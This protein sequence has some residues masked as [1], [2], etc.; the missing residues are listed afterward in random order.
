MKK[1][2]N[3]LTN[4][5]IC[6][7]FV[8]LGALTVSAEITQKDLMHNGEKVGYQVFGLGEAGNEIAVVFTKTDV[9]IPW[10]VPYDLKNVEFLV[11][12]GGGGGGASAHYGSSSPTLA[13]AGGGG[14]GVITGY[15]NFDENTT[16]LINVGQGGEGGK[17][18]AY[19]KGTNDENT[20][21]SGASLP[22]NPSVVKVGEAEYVKAMGGGNCKGLLNH[23]GE[24]ASNGGCRKCDGDG[25]CSCLNTVEKTEEE[26]EAKKD[27]YFYYDERY[28]FN[29]NRFG[30][31]GGCTYK[32]EKPAA[33]GGGGGAAGVGGRAKQVSNTKTGYTDG[34]A[35]GP[36]LESM[37]TG[38]RL[39]F[40]SGGGGGTSRKVG[41]TNQPNG[42]EGGKGGEG[43]GDG[44]KR[45]SDDNVKH[46]GDAIA[47]QGGGGG[48]AAYKGNG[49]NG[50]SGIVV[51]RYAL[52]DG[53]ALIP[54]IKSK[55]YNG[56][57]QKADV[58]ES[59][60]YTVAQSGGTDVGSYDVVL[61]L[62]EGYKWS[63][64]STAPITFEFNITPAVNKW[65]SEPSITKGS[66]TVGE[67][68]GELY[69]GKT[70]FGEIIARISKGGVDCGDF[71]GVIPTDP[72]EYEITYSVAES[73]NYTNVDSKTVAFTI[74]AADGIPPYT[75]SVGEPSVNDN[76]ELSISGSLSCEATTSK[77]A[78]IIAVYTIED[79]GVTNELSFATEI[80]LNGGAF[81]GMIRD[82]MPGATY[83]V[84]V[85]SKVGEEA[86]ALTEFKTV[87]VPGVAKNLTAEAT[88]TTTP[89][90]KF[91]ITGSV[92][93]GIGE[94][95]VTLYYSLNST[96]C[97]STME[98]VV[99]D[100]GTFA[101]E[102]SYEK[103]TDN[104]S[105][106]VTVVNT[107]DTGT[108][109]GVLN[110]GETTKVTTERKEAAHS[111]YVWTGNGEDNL[112]TNPLN[113]E[114]SNN[115]CYG[116]PGVKGINYYLSW[117]E[118]VS[119]PSSPIDLSGGVYNF[120]DNGAFVV[121]DG[122]AVEFYNGT[123]RVHGSKPMNNGDDYKIGRSNSTMT[124]N[125]VN[126]DNLN[127]LQPI[128]GSTIEFKGT[129]TQ[130][131]KYKPYTGS[132][133]TKFV[134]RDGVLTTGY[135]VAQPGSGSEVLIS[136][137]VWVVTNAIYEKD[138]ERGLAKV[139]KFRDG[140]DNQAR[141]LLCK[142]LTDATDYTLELY[143]TY[144][145]KIPSDGVTDAYVVADYVS[146]VDNFDKF[147]IDVTDYA[148]GDLIPLIYQSGAG[149]GTNT[150]MKDFIAERT[151]ALQLIANGEDV[152]SKRNGRL[153]WDYD[154][155]TLYFQQDIQAVAQIGDA[156][157]TSLAEAIEAA[158]AGD[159][160]TLVKDIELTSYLEITKSITLDFNEKSIS[161]AD[162]TGIYVNDTNAE[163]VLTN[164]TIEASNIPV[165]VN[166]AKTVDIYDCVVR[167]TDSNEAVYVQNS[168]H[169]R[170][171]SGTFSTDNQYDGKYWVLNINDNYRDTAKI[172]VYGGTFVNFNPQNCDTEVEGYNNFCADGYKAAAGD[173]AGT[174]VVR[175]AMS[176]LKPG[177]PV[178]NISA[179]SEEDAIRKVVL[180][181]EVPAGANITKDDY[182]KYFKLVATETSEGSGIWEVAAVLDD[183]K[184]T[185]VIAATTDE[186][187]VVTP[188]IT[189]EDG[190]VTVNIENELPGLNYGVRY[191]TTVEA[192]DAAEI[193]PGFTVTPAEGDTAGFFK[194]VVDFK[195]IK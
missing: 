142:A 76:R 136:N 32:A 159:T 152:T 46:G 88:F 121:G 13:G 167:N 192:V 3:Y 17:Y 66:W 59:E 106:Y 118:F 37:I 7:A 148:K 122:V 130:G 94:T 180:T 64:N 90:K 65:V 51:L 107:F 141:L 115:S 87:T 91:V 21:G 9:D 58:P 187:G 83:S 33:A 22:G 5:A 161:R 120:I 177:V 182:A 173:V 92:T 67:V 110:G 146:S 97:A 119:S 124:F 23:G 132:T 193:V 144:D 41:T 123:L 10:T 150:R 25:I 53:V 15:V 89:D 78:E 131:W 149:T 96:E 20:S 156:K 158:S 71:D 151:D 11:V 63:D 24:G 61:T 140:A 14:G 194:V 185:P 50:G 69:C 155:K 127:I 164:G 134:V 171:Y 170:I 186:N 56:E 188:A 95:K 108:W 12:G 172:E 40:G 19:K 26:K 147:V 1:I 153:V 160:I 84:A 179:T 39:V 70:T 34:G 74:V 129:T 181:V 101:F 112:W 126:I 98:Q 105:W 62:N 116:Y 72:G 111:K 174:W 166:H 176:E 165:Y 143:G 175:K 125:E 18:S 45:G 169:V 137:A 44:A 133:S 86:S 178:T 100:D 183:T 99:N 157:F 190:N 30:N 117:V 4:K 42:G 8:V 138:E 85:Y 47:N 145:I 162:G 73:I 168:G 38:V 52:P 77:M 68:S 82:L 128:A 79:S 2:L 54:E 48:G 55:V 6:A 139:T 135:S 31:E 28:V 93:P 191:A 114:C 36:G 154:A 109:Q 49:G 16:V 113:W 80:A 163:V 27:R 29:V 103:L 43:A 104:L 189:F 102:I 81:T 195:E 75:L 35:G 57:L 60:G 184:V